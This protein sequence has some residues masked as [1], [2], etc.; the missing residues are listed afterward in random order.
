MYWKVELR[1]EPAEPF[2]VRAYGKTGWMCVNTGKLYHYRDLQFLDRYED[3]D[4]DETQPPEV[5][6]ENT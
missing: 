5:Q 3:E 4:Q 2:V 6:D 1:S